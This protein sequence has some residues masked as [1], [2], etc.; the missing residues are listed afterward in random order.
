MAYSGIKPSESE[1]ILMNNLR[2][3]VRVA[4]QKGD[5]SDQSCITFQSSNN[6]VYRLNFECLTCKHIVKIHSDLPEHKHCKD[7]ENKIAS[8]SEEVT[9]S[10]TTALTSK[11]NEIT[12]NAWEFLFDDKKFICPT[13]GIQ[14]KLK[15]LCCTCEQVLSLHLFLN[16]HTACKNVSDTD[17]SPERVHSTHRTDEASKS[18]RVPNAH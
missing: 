17:S 4:L 18:N 16:D 10:V 12:K 6:R 3:A 11:V 7:L 5:T 14:F 9:T 15:A 1:S 2:S 8:D 13:S